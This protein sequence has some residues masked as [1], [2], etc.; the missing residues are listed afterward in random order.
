MREIK[1]RTWHYTDKVMDYPEKQHWAFQWLDEGQPIKLMQ[2]TG[3]KTQDGVEI[4]EGDILRFDDISDDDAWVM[5]W[6]EEDA[7]FYLKE[8]ISGAHT[9]CFGANLLVIGNIYHSP[10]L[11]EK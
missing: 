4:Y 1:F 5:M 11:L 2:Y 9:D 8:P 10:E 7:S 6:C 3:L